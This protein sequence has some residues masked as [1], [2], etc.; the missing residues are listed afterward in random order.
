MTTEQ[1]ETKARMLAT[2]PY[3]WVADVHKAIPYYRDVLGFTV[4][5]THDYEYGGD[6]FGLAVVERDNAVLQL[7]TCECDDRR[8]TG[9]AFFRIEIEGVDALHEEYVRAGA[10]IRFEPTTQEWGVRDFQIDDPEG[11]R[12]YFYENLESEE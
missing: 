2:I 10:I 7:Q 1:R 5:F 4:C 6:R 8:H 9:L 12:I 3:V 11:N